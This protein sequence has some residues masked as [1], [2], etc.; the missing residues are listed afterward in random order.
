MQEKSELD[1]FKDQRRAIG[2][3]IFPTQEVTASCKTCN[4]RFISRENN[5][6]LF[7]PSCGNQRLV[8]ETQHVDYKIKAHYGGQ[9]K[10]QPF[11][12]SWDPRAK[13]KNNTPDNSIGAIPGAVYLSD[14]DESGNQ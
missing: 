11:I 7:C 13:R 14:A 10:T 1:K 9:S 3:N 5:T 12:N 6:V 8:K 4:V 2:I